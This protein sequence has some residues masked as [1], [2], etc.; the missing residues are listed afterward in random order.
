[1]MPGLLRNVLGFVVLVATIGLATCQ[2]MVRADPRVFYAVP[3]ARSTYGP[4][5]EG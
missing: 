4:R 5:A 2:S 3:E 1:M